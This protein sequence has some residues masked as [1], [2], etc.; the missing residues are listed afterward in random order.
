VPFTAIL[1]GRFAAFAPVIWLYGGNTALIAIVSWRIL[2]LTPEVENEHHVHG[3]EL[4]LL[5]LLA[6]ALL[7]IAWSFISPPQAPW[8]LLLN[9]IAPMLIRRPVHQ[10]K[11]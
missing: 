1:V 3:R 9:V 2:K 8:A 11:S 5:L 6:S 10:N 7:C 4:S